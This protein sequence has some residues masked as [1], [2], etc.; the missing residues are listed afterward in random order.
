MSDILILIAGI[1]SWRWVIIV[2]IDI[3]ACIGILRN[4]ILETEEN[5]H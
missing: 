4:E 1:V 3:V 2:S 5:W